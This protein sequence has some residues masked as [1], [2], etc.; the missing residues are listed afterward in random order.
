VLLF[1]QTE[2]PYVHKGN[3]AAS[4]ASGLQVLGLVTI[5]YLSTRDS[6]RREIARRESEPSEIPGT[7]EDVE[8][9]SLK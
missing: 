7:P 9:K 6:K 5:L 4:V 8:T 3:I 2:Q 1:K